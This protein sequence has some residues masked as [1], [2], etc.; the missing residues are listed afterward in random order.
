MVDKFEFEGQINHDPENGF[1]ILLDYDQVE[2]C[3]WKQLGD[4]L[5]HY[6]ESETFDKGI[7]LERV[8]PG[9]FKITIEKIEEEA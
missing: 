7:G 3:T 9:K 4:I 1:E 6:Y 2:G 5:A 8:F